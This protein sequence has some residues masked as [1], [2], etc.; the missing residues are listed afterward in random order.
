[1]QGVKYNPANSLSGKINSRNVNFETLQ[2][3]EFKHIIQENGRDL[4]VRKISTKG[5]ER[6]EKK[7]SD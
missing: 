2:Y 4:R 7:P 6:M 1:M 3:C 5:G